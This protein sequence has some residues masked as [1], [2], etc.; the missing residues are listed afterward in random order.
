MCFAFLPVL[1]IDFSRAAVTSS[2]VGD[3]LKS[4]NPMA[5]LEKWSMMT[6]THQQ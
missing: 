2:D 3:F 1:A 6:S 4:A 5:F